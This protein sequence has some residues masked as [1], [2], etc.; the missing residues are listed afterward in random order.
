VKNA[1][2]YVCCFQEVMVREACA[3]GFD[4]AVC[5]HIHHAAIKNM[6]GILYLNDCDWVESCTA[7]GE[8]AQGRLSIVR[9]PP[10]AELPNIPPLAEEGGELVLLAA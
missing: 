3:R 2:E 5:G 4:G 6:D 1:V 9:W 8:D 10:F 7:L